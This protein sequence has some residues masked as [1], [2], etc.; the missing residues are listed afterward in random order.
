MPTDDKAQTDEGRR[1]ISADA[2]RAALFRLG[3]RLKK[4]RQDSG[5]MQSDVAEELG[6]TA[7]TVRNWE[8]G[9]H[10]PP[11][12][13]IKELANRYKVSEEEL[14]E[15]PGNLL[16]SSAS[17][18]PKFPYD[19]VRV[20]PGKLSK[21]RRQAGLTQ[22]RVSEMTGLSLTAIRSYERGSARPSTGTLEVLA[23]IYNKE[24][25]WFT[26]RGCFTEEEDRDFRESV[27]PWGEKEVE[28]DLIIAAY[29]EIKQDL[30]KEAKQRMLRLMRFIHRQELS[31]RV[32]TRPDDPEIRAKVAKVLNN[33]N[34][35]E[36]GRLPDPKGGVL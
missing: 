3:A 20:D 2:K 27:A 17:A 25:G 34:R 32:P 9:R 21:A 12:Q 31:S 13:A 18:K 30:S 28:D 33:A 14:L 36:Q 19:R 23:I 11:L 35:L 1:N 24:A 6:I 5:L 4:A 10:E 8:A 16:G 29:Y 7:Q 22:A 15:N 26:P